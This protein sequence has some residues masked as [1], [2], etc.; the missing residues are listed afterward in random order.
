MIDRRWGAVAVGVPSPWQVTLG[1]AERVALEAVARKATAQAR[2]VQRA[3]IV[4]AAAD[5]TSNEAIADDLR[6]GVDTV[7]RWRRRWCEQGM[8]GLADRKRSGR[9]RRYT[10]EDRLRI[11]ATVTSQRPE[12]DSQWTQAGIA[13]FLSD[14]GI[15]RSQVGRI[16][17]DLDLK[18]HRVR[19]WLT[20]PQDPAFFTRAAEV[21]D[22]YRH[23][24]ANSVV[25]SVDEKTAM[26]ARSRRHPT[27]PPA[28]GRAERVEFEYRRHGTAS[29]TA[30]LNVHT[31]EV[32]TEELPRNDSKHF[33]RF[34]HRLDTWINKELTIHLVID[35]G[36]SHTSKATR[37]WL[38]VHP[39]FVVH[40]TPK[41]ASWLNQVE[42]FF[43][44]LG[45]RLIRRGEFNSR[46][47]LLDRIDGFTI[48]YNEDA[49]PFRWTYDGSPLKAA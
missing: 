44:I 28:P 3:R 45:R 39:R 14:T 12:G 41:H 34:L 38:K 42:I 18:P 32:I 11:V 25:I 16:L 10:P 22:L 9:P 23:C 40:H 6:C 7:R 4:L 47:N 19:G 36:S 2:Q 29:I 8:D 27:V 15:S 33:I 1:G 46:Q 43:S 48:A 17:R 49:H 24:P 37:A 30:A 21:C 13:T 35:N 5:G 26:G 20:R 31:G